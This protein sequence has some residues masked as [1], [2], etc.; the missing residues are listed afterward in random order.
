[1]S[2]ADH[3]RVT[4]DRLLLLDLYPGPNHPHVSAVSFRNSGIA[5]Q[6]LENMKLTRELR[7]QGRDLPIYQ[8]PGHE[9]YIVAK[10]E[11]SCT[12][13]EEGRAV[14]NVNEYVYEIL[15]SRV[16]LHDVQTYVVDNFKS[17]VQHM[18][19]YVRK[20]DRGE[21]RV[22]KSSTRRRPKVSSS[23]PEN[24]A[25]HGGTSN[26]D[27]RKVVKAG[28]DTTAKQKVQVRNLLR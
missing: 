5:P 6:L 18:V 11:T 24:A 19:P 1:M 27:L 15:R 20:D 3:D 25:T 4:Y 21:Q 17:R 14:A 22:V 28:T 7:L 10:V 12:R 8:D 26:I 9:Y 2:L 23:E 13:S 16:K